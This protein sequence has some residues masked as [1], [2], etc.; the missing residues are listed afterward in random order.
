MLPSSATKPSIDIEMQPMA[1]CNVGRIEDENVVKLS[2]Y[3]QAEKLV[4]IEHEISSLSLIKNVSDLEQ[5]LNQLP[6]I[7][8][9]SFQVIHEGYYSVQ[10]P[11]PL[12]CFKVYLLIN[13]EKKPWLIKSLNIHA[14]CELNVVTKDSTKNGKIYSIQE[15]TSDGKEYIEISSDIVR[16]ASSGIVAKPQSVAR[17]RVN[18]ESQL[19]L[20][21]SF[22][23]ECQI[24]MRRFLYQ[25]VSGQNL[26]VGEIARPIH[27]AVHGA[28]A[29]MWI[30]ILIA[31]RAEFGEQQAINYPRENI[32]LLMKAALLHDSGRKGEGKDTPV[33]E[34]KSGENCEDHLLAIGCSAELSANYKNA[35]IGKDDEYKVNKNFDA[36]L[37]HDA[38]CLEIMRCSKK[39]YFNQLN[40]V[41]KY[42]SDKNKLKE[43]FKILDCI[44]CF[45]Q[46][47][48][49]KQGC[50]IDTSGLKF[51]HLKSCL[52][53][54]TSPPK[55]EL[56]FADNVLHF[57][58]K[59][60]RETMPTLFGLLVQS[61]GG[62]SEDISKTVVTC[63]PLS[64]QHDVSEV[65]NIESAKNTLLMGKLANV[66]GIL[67]PDMRLYQDNG[68]YYLA[69]EKVDESNFR[70]KQFNE[71]TKPELA[72]IY[73]VAS[74]LGNPTAFIDKTDQ[75]WV[76][77]TGQVLLP[78]WEASG[79][80]G[81]PSKMERK[82]GCFGST[83]FELNGL[84][85]P[86]SLSAEKLGVA[87]PPEFL[88]KTA[89]LL[90][91]IPEKEICKAAAQLLNLPIDELLLLIE[92]FGPDKPYDLMRLK[93]VVMERIAYLGRVFPSA[94]KLPLTPAEYGAIKASGVRGYSIPLDSDEI[95]NHQAKFYQ[96]YDAQLQPKTACWLRL[97]P[98][99]THQLA[100]RLGLPIEL[101]HPLNKINNT[102]EWL[103][104]SP[105]MTNQ[106]RCSILDTL[107]Q[108]AWL[109]S[110]CQRLFK[111]SRLPEVQEISIFLRQFEEIE[112]IL[113]DFLTCKNGDVLQIKPHI[114]IIKVLP[115]I[116]PS[117]VLTAEF[118]PKTQ[119]KSRDFRYYRAWEN[120]TKIAVEH[121]KFLSVNLELPINGE[122]SKS[123]A[124]QF[125]GDT[126][127]NSQAL[128]GVV[129]LTVNGEKYED[130]ASLFKGLELIGV[131]DARQTKL[132]IQN[133]YLDS[134]AQCYGVE[135][136]EKFEHH[137]NI[138][139]E[140]WLQ[141]RTGLTR[142]LNWQENHAVMNGEWVFYR[143]E[144]DS[145]KKA[146]GD[147]CMILHNYKLYRN[148]P[149]QTILN[150]FH[151]GE[152][153]LS[154]I[155]R[156]RI[157][158]LKFVSST[159]PKSSS[160]GANF[161]FMK[162]CPHDESTKGM[163]CFKIKP[164]T[165]L[166][167]DIIVFHYTATQ[168]GVLNRHKESYK[169]S[170]V[171]FKGMTK[172]EHNETILPFINFEEVQALSES[173]MIDV[174]NHVLRDREQGHN[175]LPDQLV[176]W[177][178]GRPLA[179]FF[180]QLNF[181]GIKT[182]ELKE[183][184]LTQKVLGN[185]LLQAE[186]YKCKLTT[187]QFAATLFVQ[188][189]LIKCIFID[190]ELNKSV[191]TV[192]NLKFEQCNFRGTDL[193]NL[194][195]DN[196]TFVDCDFYETKMDI[197]TIQQS[198]FTFD[199]IDFCSSDDERSIHSVRL[200]QHTI[201]L[202]ESPDFR[203]YA[204]APKVN[205]FTRLTRALGVKSQFSSLRQY[206]YLKFVEAD[207]SVEKIEMMERIGLFTDHEAWNSVVQRRVLNEIKTN[208]SYYPS[209]IIEKRL[210]YSF[211]IKFNL[212]PNT[213]E[214]RAAKVILTNFKDFELIKLLRQVDS[215][216]IELHH[217]KHMKLFPQGFLD[218]CALDILS[219]KEKFEYIMDYLCIYMEDK[220]RS[221]QD[222][223]ERIDMFFK[224]IYAPQLSVKI[225]ARLETLHFD[226]Q[227]IY[228]FIF[229]VMRDEQS[230]RLVG[231]DNRYK[232]IA[233]NYRETQK[234]KG[235]RYK[236]LDTQFLDLCWE[237]YK[238]NLK[239]S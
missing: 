107:E 136:E 108:I 65:I 146:E 24:L 49:G 45:I 229:N 94:C 203:E 22:F 200:L 147:S 160:E 214:C 117:R 187:A 109:K 227:L 162:L 212:A 10:K 3:F 210:A 37:V 67:V 54:L 135:L 143:P 208:P 157:G 95:K 66:M 60:L 189:S 223:N 69:G 48:E 216:K 79:E 32:P 53:P 57:Q 188:C 191:I 195:F 99:A 18:T 139:R 120:E 178:D 235:E 75:C 170:A 213:T 41:K 234:A 110:E 76:S 101:Q 194:E 103:Q 239:H 140:C 104:D 225:A 201:L 29:A 150:I 145:V 85:N 238:S 232:L 96:Y 33:W 8:G 2:R 70:K 231:G 159:F 173:S 83:V 50:D 123:L 87:I 134:I 169:P 9:V 221:L 11:N 118:D 177:S 62:F 161:V 218:L 63:K 184:D 34:K 155:E 23:E 196:C 181:T 152:N 51:H 39:F 132:S 80:Y 142:E 151:S 5:W 81:F 88:H 105:E 175:T 138:N 93:R 182:L 78:D 156:L 21:G 74:V 124:I 89:E 224:V 25:P 190:S 111:S 58:L 230:E 164:S 115:R 205:L 119:F 137:E 165:L 133:Q 55:Q 222:F 7:E 166:R 158:Q 36:Q 207:Y 1:Q 168:C 176:N 73:L 174:N 125:F 86:N 211:K 16:P 14:D 26:S 236:H 4:D 100:E 193:R 56:E 12:S 6:S 172:F 197:R 122:Q 64:S 102:V 114:N 144:T 71:I 72:K 38:D 186:L 185:K 171:T 27:G 198:F 43:I 226:S 228:T 113:N 106:I 13:D 97:T 68:R 84:L 20:N 47:Q 92:R 126:A 30:P 220:E 180:E 183:L 233:M 28:R 98:E 116:F 167:T 179:S 31:L 192:R 153:L 204:K 42:S 129:K 202:G 130:V 128:H 127:A 19:I 59:L 215:E 217:L 90:K 91:T 40:T 35:I 52:N 17:S 121:D 219:K 154:R 141:R 131:S 82:V 149:Q 209:K 46:A 199:K 112:T 77:K 206:R 148:F 163:C 237:K 15:I 61:T 44:Q